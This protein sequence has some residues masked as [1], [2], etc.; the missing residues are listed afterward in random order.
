MLRAA[1]ALS[2]LSQSELARRSGVPQPVISAYERGRRQ[3]T[4]ASLYKLVRETGV[5]F[6]RCLRQTGLAS[7]AAPRPRPTTSRRP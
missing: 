3:P 5:D 4:L 6:E 7:N 1:R 2:G